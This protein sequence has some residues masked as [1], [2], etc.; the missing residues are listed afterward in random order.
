MIEEIKGV[1]NPL[2]IIVIIAILA[3]VMGTISLD[4]L[5]MI[6]KNWKPV[7]IYNLG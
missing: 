4:L 6:Q 1:G 3:E 7:F 5:K 2:T